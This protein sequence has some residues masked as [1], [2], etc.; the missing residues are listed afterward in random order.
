MI[1][2]KL[3]FKKQR[4]QVDENSN[5][6]SWSLRDA[7]LQAEEV[8]EHVL[9]DLKVFAALNITEDDESWDAVATTWLLEVGVL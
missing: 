8:D 9:T 7:M 3:V 1:Q 5:V 2:S 4:I 6:A